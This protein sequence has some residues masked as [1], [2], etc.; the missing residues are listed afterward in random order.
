MLDT[1]TAENSLRSYYKVII[2]QSNGAIQQSKITEFVT[3]STVCHIFHFSFNSVNRLVK[4]HSGIYRSKY[5]WI[6]HFYL[7]KNRACVHMTL[8]Y[9]CV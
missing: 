2:H 1:K 9:L 5:T 3:Q 6:V 8:L 7:D 4:S